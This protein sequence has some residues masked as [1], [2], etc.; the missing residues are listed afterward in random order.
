MNCKNTDKQL[1]FVYHTGI[2]ITKI[3]ING[4]LGIIKS[5]V[6][7]KTRV[8]CTNLKFDGTQGPG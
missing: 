6:G 3:S 2:S 1:L 7:T 5:L 8:K 4:I